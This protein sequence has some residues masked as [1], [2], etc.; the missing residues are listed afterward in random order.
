MGD[1]NRCFWRNCP[2]CGEEYLATNLMTRYRVDTVVMTR[3][4]MD[5]KPYLWPKAMKTDT[6]VIACVRRVV[7]ALPST[8]LGE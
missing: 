8:R 6:H 2:V 5:Q 1:G 7:A 4:Q 3:S